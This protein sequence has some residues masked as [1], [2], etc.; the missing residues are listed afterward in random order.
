M[1][2]AYTRIDKDTVRQTVTYDDVVTDIKQ[3]KVQTS[4]NSEQTKL[5]NM[6]TVKPYP[7]NATPAEK[8]TIDEWNIKN[9]NKFEKE[10]LKETIDEQTK[11][12]NM[13]KAVT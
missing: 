3:S 9:S 2:V 12:L 5:D 7:V 6:P 8:K 10:K 1:S 4:I 13:L 11:F